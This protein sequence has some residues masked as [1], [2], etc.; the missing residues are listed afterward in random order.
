MIRLFLLALAL[1]LAL[2]AQAEGLLA[3]VD[4]TQLGLGETLE[5]TLEAADALRFGKPDLQVLEA[6]FIVS[7]PRQVN[8]LATVS[9]QARAITR[10]QITLQPRQAGK[11]EIPALSLGDWHSQPIALQV[12]ERDLQAPAQLAP[13]FIDA[14]LDRERVYVQ[15][16]ALLTLRIYHSVSLYDDSR[17]S[18]LQMDDAL[19]Q[20]LGEP[21]TYERTL[22]G[23]RHG[24]IEVRYAIYP[25]RSGELLIPPQLFSATTAA[26]GSRDSAYGVQPGRQT[27]VKSPEIALTVLPIPADYPRDAAWLPA[28]SLSL[29]ESW[30]SGTPP[31]VGESVTRNLML[32]A[33]GL[34]AAQLPP[35]P[36]TRAAGLRSYPD[37]PTLADQATDE[38]LIGSREQ[39]EALV[40]SLEGELSLA[41]TEL[42]WWNTESESLE[43]AHL[44]GRSLT[45]VANPD[46]PSLPEV[47]E[48]LPTEA[49]PPA[50]LWPWQ[51]STALLAATT[52]LLLWL[53]L[54]ARRQPAIQRTPASGP[55]SRSLL[56][57]L[58]R[59]CQANDAQATRQALDAWARQQP[60]TLAE[61][62]ARNVPLS[63]ALDGLNGALYS[64]SAERWQGEALWEAIN[65]LPAP[66]ASGQEAATG[67]LPPLYPR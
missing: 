18:P 67:S 36:D 6:Q 30:S 43:R 29:V 60:E 38:G 17:L 57:D 11:L 5:L 53:W 62:A 35:L 20:R 15:A 66:L 34:P 22:N 52:L 59:A 31:R 21:R 19:V 47:A 33:E 45:V 28:R 13:V 41:A 40:A 55:S 1:T 58:R 27:Q 61:M 44:P 51:L 9:G 25:Q 46:L 50:L 54:H 2:P 24:V 63:D 3:R 32:K 39:S 12:S 64:E 42:F 65:R 23:V 4:R 8:Q 16:Q 56:D 37:Q 14:S 49:G 26:I 10:W 48:V 7:A